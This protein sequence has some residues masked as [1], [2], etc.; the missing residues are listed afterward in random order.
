MRIP[1]DAKPYEVAILEKLLLG[2]SQKQVKNYLHYEQ[3]S[4]VSRVYTKYVALF[5]NTHNN[6]DEERD[7]AA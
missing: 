3:P 7:V 1:R 5:A 2:W 6:P 4:S